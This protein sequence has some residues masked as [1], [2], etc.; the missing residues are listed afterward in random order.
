MHSG[1]PHKEARKPMAEHTP[2]PWVYRS[3]HHDD[4]GWIRDADGNLA[5]TARDGRV[6]S[7]QFDTY[8][9]AGTDPYEPNA[10]FII[11]AVNNHQPLVD[12]LDECRLQ[13]EYIHEKHGYS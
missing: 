4:W 9:S 1:H 12:M 6:W 13:L 2:T 11:K 8:R 10:T 5:A 7:D 3:H